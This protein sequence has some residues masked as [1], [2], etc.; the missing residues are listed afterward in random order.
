MIRYV[1]FVIL[2]QIVNY[3]VEN[4]FFNIFSKKQFLIIL[5]LLKILFFL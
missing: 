3:K 1:R 4:I 2:F 5:V